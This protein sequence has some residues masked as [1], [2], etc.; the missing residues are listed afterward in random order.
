MEHME[1]YDILRPVQHTK[2]R[3]I[4]GGQGAALFGSD[5]SVY[6][7]CN[8]ENAAFSP[9][10]C[11]ERVA[12]FKAIS[13]GKRNFS[14]V[15]VYSD[16]PDAEKHGFPPCGVCRQVMSEFCDSDFE[17]VLGTP[18]KFKVFKLDEV[19]PLRFTGEEL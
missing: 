15:A 19:L 13:D 11:A 4:T 12:F 10:C 14:A 9:T 3:E 7:G 17:V 16:H 1:T 2:K 5:G 8:I 6:L 18:E